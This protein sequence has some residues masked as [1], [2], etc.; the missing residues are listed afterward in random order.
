MQEHIFEAGKHRAAVYAQRCEDDESAELEVATASVSA[1]MSILSRRGDP[2]GAPHPIHH[3]HFL[4]SLLVRC[5]Q[6]QVY[7]IADNGV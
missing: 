5:L 4:C 1:A 3:Q 6:A 7:S 2:T